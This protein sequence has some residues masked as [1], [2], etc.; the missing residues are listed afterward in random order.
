[1]PATKRFKTDLTA[2]RIEFINAKGYK[3]SVADNFLTF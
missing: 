3:C 1:M 2:A